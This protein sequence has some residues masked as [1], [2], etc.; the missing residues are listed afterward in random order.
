MTTWPYICQG[1]GTRYAAFRVYAR[2]GHDRLEW[3]VCAECGPV[4]PAG[5]LAPRAGW[6][7]VYHTILRPVP[8][9]FDP[10]TNPCPGGAIKKRSEDKRQSEELASDILETEDLSG[11]EDLLETDL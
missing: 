7:D 5:A 8:A 3:T 4:V 10:I 6:S 1:C 9:L 2:A 11:T